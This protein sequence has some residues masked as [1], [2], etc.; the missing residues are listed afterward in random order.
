MAKVESAQREAIKNELINNHDAAPVWRVLS[1]PEV[2]LDDMKWLS[3]DEKV[4]FRAAITA[5]KAEIWGVTYSAL[6]GLLKEAEL[7]PVAASAAST[8]VASAE[9]VN[10]KAKFTK[11]PPP[12]YEKW[13]QKYEVNP[14]SSFEVITGWQSIEEMGMIVK[15]N[16]NLMQLR[17]R[18]QWVKHFDDMLLW[19]VLNI[20]EEYEHFGRMLTDIAS[21][22]WVPL[23]GVSI[24][25][26]RDSENIVSLWQSWA[27][28]QIDALVSQYW[29][30][31]T[32]VK[33]A[34]PFWTSDTKFRTT[35]ERDT[36]IKKMLSNMNDAIIAEDGAM[37]MWITLFLTT[38]L[39]W[40]ALWATL[41]KLLEWWTI[42][43]IGW[44]QVLAITAELYEILDRKMK[45]ADPANKTLWDSVKDRLHIEK[46]VGANLADLTPEQKELR[47]S[48]IK[49]V[50]E[51]VRE[52]L[53][54]THGGGL[55]HE[56]F[57]KK[58]EAGVS[59]RSISWALRAESDIMKRLS[60][61]LPIDMNMTVTD[62]FELEQKF[63]KMAL[64]M[65][66][67][68][69]N[70]LKRGLW[71]FFFE[72]W[73]LTNL[74][75]HNKAINPS[76]WTSSG[77]YAPSVVGN[78]EAL[79]GKLDT[80]KIEVHGVELIVPK[81]RAEMIKWVIEYVDAEVAAEAVTKERILV[82]DIRFLEN[83]IRVLN[84]DGIPDTEQWVKDLEDKLTEAQRRYTEFRQLNA[85]VDD[86]RTKRSE[87]DQK[88]KDA[89][90]SKG[91]A[92]TA[93][94]KARSNVVA[95]NEYGSALQEQE[96]TSRIEAEKKWKSDV[97]KNTLT[98]TIGTI[99]LTLRSLGLDVS[100]FSLT[101]DAADFWERAQEHIRQLQEKVVAKNRI[102]TMD[103]ERI[104]VSS[105]FSEVNQKLSTVDTTMAEYKQAQENTK[106]TQKVLDAKI[107]ILT[108][109]WIWDS[110]QAVPN[111]DSRWLSEEVS[112]REAS[113]KQATQA[114]TDAEAE[115]KKYVAATDKIKW[116]ISAEPLMKGVVNNPTIPS[117]AGKA[118]SLKS[119]WDLTAQQG[120]ATAM[121]GHLDQRIKDQWKMP[122]VE[123]TRVE[124]LI[125]AGVKPEDAQKVKPR[126]DGT[127]D[128]EGTRVLDEI[129]EKGTRLQSQFE[130]WKT[131]LPVWW[132]AGIKDG[133]VTIR[134]SAWELKGS[135]DTKN[136]KEAAK[137]VEKFWRR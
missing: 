52:S 134:D 84:A 64:D 41:K 89:Q 74:V 119:P 130:V 113:L 69:W 114:V 116:K 14:S 99:E 57:M 2:T 109:I 101:T 88:L 80:V 73:S 42:K 3:A 44:K 96:R 123:T 81:A 72:K 43:G 137:F 71:R 78:A 92:E 121:K 28:G 24:T 58:M 76:R 136:P 90:T 16:N 20:N 37:G 63:S 18:T 131:T 23:F 38:K 87:A 104:D 51:V 46:L 115:V 8:A 27:A 15:R 49:W 60:P 50:R 106:A 31:W 21:R 124:A 100:P 117:V 36:E 85:A 102:V 68:T 86:A 118:H 83:R 66:T 133:K 39:G 6:E 26:A 29:D 59:E 125:R 56:D 103:A 33:N 70:N 19:S 127:L 30:G 126:A 34:R 45:W 129:I 32:E 105:I 82:D 10:K 122:W 135:F 35:A 55:T 4:K 62:R 67:S 9:N 7:P 54:S 111:T 53:Y 110:V 120:K 107:K 77:S 11:E 132:I 17:V 112:T 91:E 13:S 75:L 98:R 1:G 94:E 93:L 47:E 65:E 48:Q 108:D 22:T 128:A 79:M 25:N 40:S 95:Y 12:A 5:R 97:A 61:N